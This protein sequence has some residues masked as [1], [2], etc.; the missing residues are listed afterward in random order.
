MKGTE[1]SEEELRNARIFLEHIAPGQA[2]DPEQDHV[3]CSL[4]RHHLVRL[5]AWYGSIR[6]KG[7]TP[8]QLIDLST[9]K[10]LG[11]GKSSVPPPDAR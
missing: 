8:G 1:V 9:S 10:P 11:R 2:W 6:S 5:V 7:Q 3:I 4:P